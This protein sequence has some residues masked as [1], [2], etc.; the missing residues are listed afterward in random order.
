[1][2]S[3][4]WTDED[5]PQLNGQ[6]LDSSASQSWKREVFSE[7]N[8]SRCSC[9]QKS[10]RKRNP[11]RME[12]FPFHDFE[13][14]S[15]KTWCILSTWLVPTLIVQLLAY[16]N[17][18]QDWSTS[19]SFPF[20]MPGVNTSDNSCLNTEA[21]IHSYDFMLKDLRHWKYGNWGVEQMEVERVQHSDFLCLHIEVAHICKY[22]LFD[23]FPFSTYWKNALDM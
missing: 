13:A 6:K 10:P 14:S 7:L 3:L 4:C 22:I 8:T 16:V 1:M 18:C 11:W 5:S 17:L 20:Q 21:F 12:T 9:S 15:R 19:L 23:P 2:I